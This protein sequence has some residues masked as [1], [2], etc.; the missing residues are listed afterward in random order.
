MFQWNLHSTATLLHKQYHRA[1]IEGR[2]STGV[3][4]AQGHVKRIARYILGLGIDVRNY[5]TIAECHFDR[6]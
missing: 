4:N 1:W 2:C 6:L 3:L 5:E